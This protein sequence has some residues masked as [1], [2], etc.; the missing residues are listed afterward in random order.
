VVL[1]PRHRRA[2]GDA[3]GAPSLSG[4][5]DDHQWRA[6]GHRTGKHRPAQLSGVLRPVLAGGGVPRRWTPVSTASDA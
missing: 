4:Q 6:P 1:V 5:H 2:S 3:G